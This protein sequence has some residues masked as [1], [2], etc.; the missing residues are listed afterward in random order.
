MD[1]K[2]ASLGQLLYCSRYD[3]KYFRVKALEELFRR[4][5]E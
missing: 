5:G 2:K 1:F 4:L 3:R